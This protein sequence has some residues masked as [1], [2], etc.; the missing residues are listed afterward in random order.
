[1][2]L[3]TM[4]KVIKW[5][6]QKN[7]RLINQD[8]ALNWWCKKSCWYCKIWTFRYKDWKSTQNIGLIKIV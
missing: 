1:M 8:S 4:A 3:G 2:N 7:T 6:Y 5:K